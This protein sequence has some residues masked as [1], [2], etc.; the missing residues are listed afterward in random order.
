ME[1]GDGVV[2]V[3][4]D[5]SEAPGII[6]DFSSCR[7]G[8]DVLLTMLRPLPDSEFTPREAW[9]RCHRDACG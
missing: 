5:F 3:A 4:A 1:C 7:C 6:G 8:V 2:P 9:L